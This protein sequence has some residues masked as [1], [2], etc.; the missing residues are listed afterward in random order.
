MRTILLLCLLV[1]AACNDPKPKSD[2]T[3]I[4]LVVNNSLGPTE[5]T[6][7]KIDS[8]L[9]YNFYG[10]WATDKTSR[11]VNGGG[12]GKISRVLWDTLTTRLDQIDYEKLKRSNG[13]TADAQELEIIVH[14]KNRIEHLKAEDLPGNASNIFYDVANSYI[15]GKMQNVK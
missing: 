6:E 13:T 12:S 9:N 4:E 5:I 7:I 1:L 15:T 2:I 10:G 8:A 14:Y 3:D 11:V